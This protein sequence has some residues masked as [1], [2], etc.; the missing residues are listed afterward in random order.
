MSRVALIGTFY[1]R[2]D[3]AP[4]IAAAIR[5]Q[6]REPDE[7]W[8]MHERP[9]D[10]AYLS[11]EDWGSAARLASVPIE[12]DADGRPLVTPFAP[13]INHALDHS[14]ADLNRVASARI[15]ARETH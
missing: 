8:L 11:R 6:T 9:E 7:V 1:N 10:G 3:D 13:L 5:S 14:S 12:R 15:L 2:P 4:V